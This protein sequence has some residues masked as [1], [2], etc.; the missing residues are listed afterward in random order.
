MVRYAYSSILIDI[1][2][3]NEWVSRDRALELLGVQAQSL[4]AY[5]SR[6]QIGAQPDPVDPRRS[7]YRLEDVSALLTKRR[8]GR[9]A[10]SIAETA[11]N[12]G[13]PI[14]PTALST[15]RHGKLYYR[16]RDAIGLASSQSL[17]DVAGL[18]WQ[19]SNNVRF[20][21]TSPTAS[22]PFAALGGL[23]V[24]AEP[25]LGCGP[26]RLCRDAAEV[27]GVIASALGCQSSKEPVHRRLAEAWRGSDEA[28]DSIRRALV[29]MADHD[30][31][32]S[33][34]AVRVAASTGASI[35]ASVLAGLCALSGPRHGG[36]ASLLSA[37]L[38]QA[39]RSDAAQACRDWM[40]RQIELPGFGHPL[41]PHGDPRCA[42]LLGNI[43]LDEP[44]AAMR[45]AVG[46]I[47]S[48]LPNCDFALAALK[49]AHDLP[50]DAPF[51]IFLLARSVGWCAHAME[52]IL[53][54]QLIRP[55][56]RYVGALPDGKG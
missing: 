30:L 24:T 40:A 6:G 16:G 29:V 37:L 21:A 5:V 1:I 23:A 22:S 56:G 17:E 42:H 9:K 10:R 49:R 11:L 20:A 32:A 2:N 46:D 36:A 19:T 15:A 12:W 44:M 35:A 27:V 4:Y 48:R 13:E 41:Y 3:M 18:L 33:T 54:G 45:D 43:V 8:R 28:A 14:I 55:S 38:D 26:E 34:F 39:A 50:P 25:S 7:L 47:T 31:N 52:Q 53:E 51:G